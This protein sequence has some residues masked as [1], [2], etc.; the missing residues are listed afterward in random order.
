M[1]LTIIIF[2][3]LLSILVLAHEWG[4]FFTARRFGVGAEEFG[5]GFPPRLFGWYR[6]M[7]GKGVFFWGNKEVTDAKNTVYS[8]NLIPIG[9]FVKIKGEN[10]EDKTDSS[11]FGN[12]AIWKRAVILSAGVFMNIVLAAVIITICLSFGLPQALD[13]GAL[14]KGAII[15]DRQIQIMQV[16]AKSPAEQASLRAGDAIVSINSQTFSSYSEVQAFVADKAGKPLDYVI[17]RGN[18]KI[19][20]T[21]TPQILSETK[22][23]GIGIS[24]AETG[25][26]RYPWY[27]AIIEGVKLTGLLLWAIIVGLASLIAQLFSGKSV[28][29]QVTGPIGIATL[30]GQMAQ[31][32]F[33]YL[34]QFAALLSLNLAVINF[35]PFPALDGGRVLFLI[36]EKIKGSPVKQKTEAIIHNLGFFL[37]IALIILVTYKD[38][39]KLF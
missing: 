7:E 39:I 33:A 17:Q 26:V 9:G 21:I 5:L 19:N 12:K 36:I 23:A 38:I 8:F 32:G 11:S 13:E 35:V 29:A 24:I 18:E 14:P 30:T 22:K 4:H 15:R 6:N 28:A 27:I 37:L 10:G 1:I 20:K 2:L 31:L 25:V 34:A 16:V 3:V